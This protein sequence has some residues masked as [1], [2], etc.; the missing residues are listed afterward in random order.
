MIRFMRVSLLGLIRVQPTCQLHR[1][2][3]PSVE[4]W[5]DR[6]R[7]ETMIALTLVFVALALV[8]GFALYRAPRTRTVRAGADDGSPMFLGTFAVGSS[9]GGGADCGTGAD[10]SGGGCGDGDGGGGAD[11]PSHALLR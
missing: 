3:P 2:N 8:I 7:R 5:S 6:S 1:C 10:G 4:L 9:D 11:Y